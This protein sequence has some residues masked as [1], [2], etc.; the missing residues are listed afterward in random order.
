MREERFLALA[1]SDNDIP[2]CSSLFYGVTPAWDF[3]FISGHNSRHAANIRANPRV[4]WAIFRG[5]ATPEETDGVQFGGEA[6][7]LPNTPSTQGLADL[8]YD[9]R[10]PDPARRSQHPADLRKFES[11]GRRI[12]RLRPAEV[13]KLDPAGAHGIERMELSLETLIEHQAR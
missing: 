2:W 4:A 9:Q 12:Y 7:E 13:H 11:T 6:E 8:L 10:F 1:T 5:H 3:L